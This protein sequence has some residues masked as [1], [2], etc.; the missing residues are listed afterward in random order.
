MRKKKKEVKV[1]Y[2]YCLVFQSIRHQ[3]RHRLNIIIFENDEI[4]AKIIIN[5]N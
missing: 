4:H 1:A 3:T 2:C 5:I